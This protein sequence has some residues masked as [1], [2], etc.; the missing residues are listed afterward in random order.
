[1]ISLDGS[2]YLSS[3]INEFFIRTIEDNKEIF[4][5]N[6]GQ[7][8]IIKKVFYSTGKIS[9]LLEST[10]Q[11]NGQKEKGIIYKVCIIINTNNEYK[12]YSCN[13]N[14]NPKDILEINS[15][16]VTVGKHYIELF[17]FNQ[18]NNNTTL[19]KLSEIKFNDNEEEKYSILSVKNVGD[20]LMCTHNSGHISLWEQSTEYPYLK[21]V[22]LKRIHLDA[23]N[24]IL[25]D[26]YENKDV[27]ISCSSDKTVKVHEIGDIVCLKV[28]EFNEEVVNIVKV[29]NYEG[30]AYYIISLKNGCLKVYNASF[31]EVFEIPVR[32]NTNNARCVLNI[33]K[34]NNNNNKEDFILISEKNKID[35]YKWNKK[36]QNQMLKQ[37]DKTNHERNYLPQ[38]WNRKY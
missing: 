30:K 9:L 20:K 19:S 15:V 29:F 17:L 24:A 8:S 27:L 12:L 28:I 14:D 23:I 10:N 5:Q 32:S 25:K 22:S 11:I 7:N 3:D 6:V 4:K 38:K 2:R 36:N 33:I 37:S 26:I 31:K 13:T 34:T 16:I 21:N 35:V 1:M 18:N